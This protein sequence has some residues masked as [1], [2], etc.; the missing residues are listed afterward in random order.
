M[1]KHVPNS[2]NGPYEL[3]GHCGFTWTN[4]R[5]MIHDK[6]LIKTKRMRV[7]AG[8]LRQL[9]HRAAMSSQEAM[10]YAWLMATSHKLVI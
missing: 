7:E 3:Y 8:Q 10:S 2:S 4:G 9:A 5:Y 6:S 1:D